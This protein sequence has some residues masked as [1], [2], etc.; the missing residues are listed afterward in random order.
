MQFNF[1]F[2][3][4]II[5]ALATNHFRKPTL[6]FMKTT[7][8]R[9][10]VFSALFAFSFIFFS[11]KQHELG[12]T[13]FP[14]VR[15]LFVEMISDTG[16]V[17]KGEIIDIPADCE[18]LDYGF[19]WTEYPGSTTYVEKVSLGTTRNTGEFKASASRAMAEGKKYYFKAF[20][21]TP[22]LTIF[23]NEMDFVSLGSHKP[24][25][26]SITPAT[27]S[28][29]DTIVIH[30]KN[31]SNNT[32]QMFVM[33]GD[34]TGMNVSSTSTEIKTIV[35]I[36]LDTAKCK[37]GI[38]FMNVL[39]PGEQAFTLVPNV[40]V[41]SIEPT[42]GSWNTTVKI[43]GKN[44]KYAQGVFFNNII[45]TLKSLSDTVAETVV[46]YNLNSSVSDVALKINSFRFKA[47]Q[48][49]NFIAG[50]IKSIT[51]ETG[52]TGTQV[53]I[54][55]NNIRTLYAKVSIN[56][57]DAPVKSKTDTTLTVSMPLL[58]KSG[59]F[60]IVISDG[61]FSITY[62]NV[63]N[64]RIPEVTSLSDASWG[65]T[66]IITG[67]NFDVIKNWKVYFG[68]TVYKAEN[69]QV[70]SVS[71][72]ALKVL[73][74]L[75]HQYY[76]K[77]LFLEGDNYVY[78][79][80]LEYKIPD[81]VI[82]EVIGP[83]DYK[84][85]L[86]TIKGKYFHPSATNVSLQES[87]IQFSG[88][89][90]VTSTIFQCKMPAS[91]RGNYSVVL[92]T[93]GSNPAIL[94][95]CIQWDAPVKLNKD[96]RNI[97]FSGGNWSFYEND[98]T[99]N[100]F[101]S[102]RSGLGNTDYYYDHNSAAPIQIDNVFPKINTP[103]TFSG[104]SKIFICTGYNINNGPISPY[105]VYLKSFFEFDPATRTY[106][107]L[108]DFPGQGR[109][110]AKGFSYNG[111]G[112]LI[113]GSSYNSSTYS[114]TT[115]NEIWEYDISSK[116]WTLIKSIGI[117]RNVSIHTFRVGNFIYI[118]NKFNIWKFDPSVNS[119]ENICTTPATS[120]Q[121]STPQPFYF[122]NNKMYFQLGRFH[123][124][125][126]EFDLIQKKWSYLF[127][128]P[129]KY[130]FIQHSYVIGNMAYIVMHTVFDNPNHLTLVEFDPSYLK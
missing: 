48:K 126:W 103:A 39:Y 35:P 104:G 30:G 9:L 77:K 2:D 65:D 95:N 61:S 74:S 4:N 83:T 36:E 105:Y 50:N 49:F 78:P 98:D 79:E 51:P 109:A 24:E 38:K 119:L 67:R 99:Q 5:F 58:P 130:Q 125:C 101:I 118:F 62:E 6:T 100:F 71:S 32:Y 94:S 45:T 14:R 114:Y 28:W 23:G 8:N 96:F 42:S 87:G 120:D 81:P 33:F 53:T 93:P 55:T 56:G 41:T 75:N 34:K 26:T 16:A 90:K 116:K 59:N 82:Q 21:Q 69:V 117:D 88:A 73:I 108:N 52:T 97:T 72:S 11:C 57:T 113:G 19:V 54:K 89:S 18:I 63:F 25:I 31:F 102:L 29:G 110:D 46:P 27:G 107:T 17:F 76:Y 37:I 128:F 43:K 80:N 22:T 124:E 123:D 115:Y 127:N 68:E 111:K 10:T 15:T 44:L 112:Y 1:W 129:E 3:N 106:T 86:I 13:G 85:P 70:I 12:D 92:S 64:Y 91:F 121:Y 66:L 60:P 122:Q 7:L 20:I 40:E 47:S 84:N